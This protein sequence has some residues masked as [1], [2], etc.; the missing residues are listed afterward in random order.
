MSG[1]RVSPPRDEDSGSSIITLDALG[2]EENDHDVP[3]TGDQGPH[4]RKRALILGRRRR[5][6][7]F[8][9]SLKVCLVGESGGDNYVS[10]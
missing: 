8:E 7:P 5:H 10:Q 1:L 2:I 6:E 9:G 3:A 4:S